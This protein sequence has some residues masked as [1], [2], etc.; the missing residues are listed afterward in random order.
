MVLFRWDSFRVTE[1]CS[2]GHCSGSDFF[3]T[4]LPLLR[5]VLLVVGIDACLRFNA[6]EFLVA[7]ECVDLFVEAPD[8]R[9]VQALLSG[10]VNIIKRSI[11][12]ETIQNPVVILN[13]ASVNQARINSQPVARAVVHH[14]RCHCVSLCILVV[15]LSEPGAKDTRRRLRPHCGAV[16][17]AD[18]AA[19][20]GANGCATIFE[21]RTWIVGLA[22]CSE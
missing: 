18:A 13:L 17:F 8:V 2:L 7:A 10:I 3:L 20:A 19:V 21:S 5:R 4:L 22:M 6:I 12:T 9:G 14:D 15:V 1:T 11:M 16:V